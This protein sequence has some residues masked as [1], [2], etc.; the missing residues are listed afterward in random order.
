VQS[1]G[2]AT[3]D[4][5]V[6]A[7]VRKLMKAIKGHAAEYA[8]KIGLLKSMKRAVY[9][10]E[11]KGH[12]GLAKANYTHFTSPIRRYADLIVHRVLWN[13]TNASKP[14][15]HLRTPRAA[16]MQDIAEHISNTERVA[17]DA[18]IESRRLKELEYLAGLVASKEQVVFDALVLEARRIGLFVELSDYFIKGL[19]KQDALEPFDHYT[20]DRG[21]RRFRGEQHGKVYETGNRLKVAIDAVDLERKFVDFRVVRS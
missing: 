17:A 14:E 20:W 16:G 19:I 12:F 21:M 10:A 8:I 11:P 9:D 3:G 6:P 13:L 4:L 15:L 7:E 2:I 18:E 1:L 5:T